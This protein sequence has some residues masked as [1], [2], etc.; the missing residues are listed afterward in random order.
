MARGGRW[1]LF[2]S[3]V[4]REFRGAGYKAGGGWNRHPMNGIRRMV[5][6]RCD[7]HKDRLVNVSSPGNKAIVQS[8][9]AIASKD[10]D[11]LGLALA[12]FWYFHA[13]NCG[14]VKCNRDRDTGSGGND[15]THRCG[16][17]TTGRT[18]GDH[19]SISKTSCAGTLPWSIF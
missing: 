14:R 7:V 4:Q 2:G 10:L 16:S 6:D 12:T 3:C 13:L 11:E 19:T 17:L 18:T 15:E 1:V 5:E 8:N 9:V